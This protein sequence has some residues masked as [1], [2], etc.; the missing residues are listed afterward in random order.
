MPIG[1]Q[2]QFVDVC[3]LLFEHAVDCLVVST[4]NSG[5]VSRQAIVRFEDLL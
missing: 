3:R 1:L 4:R 2:A 5:D